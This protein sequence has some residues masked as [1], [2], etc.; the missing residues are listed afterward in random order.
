M[1][2]KFPAGKVCLVTG[3]AGGLGKAIAQAFLNSGAKVVVSDINQ[4]VLKQC[5]REFPSQ[6]FRAVNADV[7]KEESGSRIFAEVVG[8]F[9]KLDVLVNNAG[10][11]DHF[12]GAGGLDK[13]LAVNLTGPFIMTK[14]AVQHLLERK[15]KGTIL[16]I[17]SLASIR[18]GTAGKFR[19]IQRFSKNLSL[20]RCCLYR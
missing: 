7:T 11:M 8:Q 5:E 20:C 17:G 14:L 4:D 1:L 10:I 19:N 15:S 2:S 9:G 13:V 16:N 6:D 3:G 12:D 18:G